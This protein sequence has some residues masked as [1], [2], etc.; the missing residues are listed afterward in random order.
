LTYP[1]GAPALSANVPYKVTVSAGGHS[2]DEDKAPNLGFS[3]LS[4]D[5]AERVR[6]SEQRLRSLNLPHDTALLLVAALYASNDLNGAAIELLESV[7]ATKEPVLLLNLADLLLRVQRIDDVV[8][9][10]QEAADIAAA[11]GDSE[12]EAIANEQLGSVYGL[13]LGNAARALAHIDRAIAIYQS[14]G[15]EK[16][17]D[18]LKQKRM[19]LQKS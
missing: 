8:E 10:Y 13:A 18:Q 5:Q 1:Q 19:R 4:P 17:L 7:R 14:L 12:S 16:H 15:D 9:L 6:T 3:V 11:R 2:S